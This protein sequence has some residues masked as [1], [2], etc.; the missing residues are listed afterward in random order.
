MKVPITSA[1]GLFQKKLR[2]LMKFKPLRRIGQIH[3][4]PIVP[5]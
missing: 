4:V 2:I 3:L 5:I 1:F